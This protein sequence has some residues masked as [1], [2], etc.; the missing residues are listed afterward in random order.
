MA[1][2]PVDGAEPLTNAAD[3]GDA[4]R[5]K[6]CRLL[7]VHDA[8][9]GVQQVV[10]F[11][12]PRRR[13]DEQIEVS[14][15]QLGQTRLL[16]ATHCAG[17]HHHTPGGKTDTSDPSEPVPHR[18]RLFQKDEASQAGNPKQVHDSAEERQAH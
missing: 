8:G 3:D 7:S 9:P 2:Q 15:R 13:A 17:E 4:G 5:A 16:L 1:C 10:R 12:A 18:D 6:L 11:A 14:P